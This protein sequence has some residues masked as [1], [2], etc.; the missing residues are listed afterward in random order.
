M[1]GATVGGRTDQPLETGSGAAAGVGPQRPEGQS[2]P[3]KR[4]K[5]EPG[6]KPQSPDFRIPES[7]WQYRGPK[8]TPPKDSVGG[9]KQSEQLRPTPVPG[10][11][12]SV[13]PEPRAPAS[14][15]PRVPAGPEQKAS[16]RPEQRAPAEPAPSPP[17][18]ERAAAGEVVATRAVP[19][20]PP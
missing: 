15:K 8:T 17:R 2:P 1:G 5:A 11:S 18:K 20:R 16:A 10:P 7:Q 3:P 6:P 14:S 19:A 12:V 9:Q 13:D 4:R